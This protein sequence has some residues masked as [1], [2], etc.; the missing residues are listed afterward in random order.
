MTKARLS[1]VVEAGKRLLTSRLRVPL[2]VDW[3]VVAGLSYLF[4][5]PYLD[6]DS[7]IHVTGREFESNTDIIDIARIAI[8]DHGE[9]P[10]WN[11][12]LN[13]GVPYFS[14]PMNHLL[15]PLASVPGIILGPFNGP[16][17]AVFLTILAAGLAFY[18]L[19]TVL[20][21]WRPVRIWAALAYAFN[22]HMMARFD[23]G[24][25]DFGLAFAF[26]P[27]A[28]AFTI[29]TLRRP[30]GVYPFLGGLSIALVLFS[31]NVYYSVY[32]VPALVLA[33]VL[34]L[35][36]VRGESPWLSLNGQ[37]TA[38]LAAMAFWTLGIAA[39]QLVAYY[40]LQDYM[41][42][43]SDRLLDTSQPVVGSL[44]DYV[45]SDV[46]F[47]DSSSYGKLPGFLHEYYSYVG[48]APYVGVLLLPLALVRGRRRDVLFG[49][50][51]FAFYIAWASAGHTPFRRLMDA[52]P[53]LYKLRWTS[54]VLGPAT[55]PL[56]LLAALGFDGL[57]TVYEP[58]TALLKRLRNYR[59][60]IIIAATPIVLAAGVFLILA[61]RDEYEA[62][63]GFIH[64][65]RANPADQEVAQTLARITNEA[66][67][68]TTNDSRGGVPA[69][70]YQEGLQR[71]GAPWAW[72]LVIQMPEGGNLVTG[73]GLFV[74]R[75]HFLVL[76]SD[77]MPVEADAQFIA[78]A[79]GRNIYRLPL[80]LPLTFTARSAD[81]PFGPE[82]A[83]QS[84]ATKGTARI[85]SPNRFEV[86][87]DPG[88]GQ[89][90]LVLLQTYFPGWK[91]KVDGSSGQ[92]VSNLGGYLATTAVPGR[93]TYVFAFDPAPQRYGLAIS[94]GTILGAVFLYT[95]HRRR[96]LAHALG[97]AARGARAIGRVRPPRR[98]S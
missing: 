23:M 96:R 36:E 27:L 59:R 82:P 73:E 57:R 33:V 87:A 20:D 72:D 28:I 4:A 5:K 40:Q 51:L 19:L 54:R 93:H 98:A 42:K 44:L 62:N 49:V 91:V 47:Y 88:L 97:H 46:Q 55:I 41:L 64:L 29:Q 11:P 52:V 34:Y 85:R 68:V 12:F 48:W 61:L 38:R 78:S 80:S 56:L 37:T 9:F 22:G 3:L 21:I 31:G 30:G 70:F 16:K 83:W 32:L 65:A 75:P 92:K 2:A 13:T 17:V 25:F 6:L 95:F 7:N 60:L 94:A 8:R 35:F 81:P 43:H 63:R 45:R 26:L 15:N 24:H 79:G 90:T 89:D 14:D 76:S 69:A 66:A 67:F 71:L 84:K 50:A 58:R 39:A 18:Y 86:E 1:T 53:W 77:T 74:P 10:F